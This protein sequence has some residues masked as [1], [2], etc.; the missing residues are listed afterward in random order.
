MDM[1]AEAERRKRAEILQSEGER[2]AAI[3]TA[4]GH[5]QSIVLK[6][7]GEAESIINKARATAIGITKVAESLAQQRGNDAVALRV[8][9]QYI[10]AFSKLAKKGNTILLPSNAA[11]PASMIAQAMAVFQSIPR[12]SVSLLCL[13]LCLALI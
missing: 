2:E 12:P 4:E 10:E 11:D 13:W 7:Q 9:E 1:Q 8:A 3:N 5:R 6:A